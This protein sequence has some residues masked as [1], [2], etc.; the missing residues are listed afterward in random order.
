MTRSDLEHI[1]RACGT[2]ADVDEIVIIGSRAVLGEFPSAPAE[3]SGKAR[4]SKSPSD[5]ML[6]ASM[7]PLPFFPRDG[8][9]DWFSPEIARN[10]TWRVRDFRP[11]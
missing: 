11:P 10:A 5:I 6:M 1:I 3:R 7:R 9:T 4:R 8:V 2:I